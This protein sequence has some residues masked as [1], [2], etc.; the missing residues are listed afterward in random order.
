MDIN[1]SML[2]GL[3]TGLV[4]VVL[5]IFKSRPTAIIKQQETTMLDSEDEDFDTLIS[6]NQSGWSKFFTFIGK[7]LSYILLLALILLV[8]GGLW[9]WIWGAT[10]PDSTIM[11]KPVCFQQVNGNKLLGPEICSSN[12]VM[13]WRRVRS[14]C[15]LATPFF[16]SKETTEVWLIHTNPAKRLTRVTFLLSGYEVTPTIWSVGNPNNIQH[17]PQI[18]SI[19]G[20][21]LGNWN[22]LFKGRTY[23]V[24]GGND[25]RINTKSQYI[26][27]VIKMDTIKVVGRKEIKKYFLVYTK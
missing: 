10:T 17:D 9:W 27:P 24:N 13:K 23:G 7:S 22:H 1:I 5:V 18:S 12:T 25:Y 19:F 16:C 2:I 15:Y 6:Q 4:V 3:I 20:D 26:K 14:H 21:G 8:V 11:S